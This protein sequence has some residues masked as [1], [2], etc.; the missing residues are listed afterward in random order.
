MCALRGDPLRIAELYAP[1]QFRIV[2]AAAP[3][4]G[5][6]EV[7]VRVAAVG[8][9]GSD[10]HSYLEGSVGDV[11][12][13]YPMV[14]GHEPAGVVLKTGAGVTGWDAGARAAF[15]PAIYCYHCEYCLSGHHNV[16][17]RLRFLSQPG[18]PGFFRDVVN[19]PVR[20][21]QAIPAGLGLRDATL[22]EPLAVVVHSMKF[23]R[24]QPGETAVVFGAGPIGLLT[25][26]CLRLAGASRVFVVEPV[27]HRRELALALGAAEAIDPA[28]ADP[29]REVF[30]ATGKRGA[31]LAI[32]CAAKHAS[33][34]Q[35][36]RVVRNASRVVITGIPAEVRVPVD[37]H[38]M[39]RREITLYNV[40]RSNH[41]SPVA[42]DLLRG[43]P[44]HFVPMIT[45]ERPLEAIAGA[46]SIVERYAD[47]I[48]KLIVTL[49]E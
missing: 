25:L 19:L 46:F 14:L 23:A 42:L 11:E 1:R 36:L 44:G 38:A 41:E 43:H 2:E 49:G 22:I 48:G 20:N 33:L 15:E 47:G 4:P 8:I 9:C 13:R 35:C 16:C 18:E 7:Q 37:F 12:A 3:D 27:A 24:V 5:P 32:D 26:G 6:G 39:R 29:A 34:D 31:D 30:A 45:H 40:R 28:A 10:L 17:A 21:L